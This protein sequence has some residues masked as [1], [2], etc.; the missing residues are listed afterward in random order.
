M[1]LHSVP[2]RFGVAGALRLAAL[3]HLGML[4]LLFLLPA[5]YPYFGRVFYAGVAA[6]AL[7]LG[8]E[9]W[10][11]RPDDLSRVIGRSFRSMRW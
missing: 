10:I 1:R 4:I 3:C 9:H 8:Y 7:L 6:I 11:V 2:A 5:A